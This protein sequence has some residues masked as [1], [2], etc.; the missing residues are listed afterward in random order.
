MPAPGGRRGVFLDRDGVLNQSLVRD[1]K[2]YAP[3]TLEEFVLLPGAAEAVCAL[4]ERGFVVVVVTNQPDIGNGLVDAAV[5]EAMHRRLRELTLVDDIRVCPHKQTDGCE[6][7]KPKPGMLLAAARDHGIDLG[8]SFMIGDRV[9]DLSAGKAAGCLTAF[10]DHG[11]GETKGRD[12][13]PDIWA[14]SLPDATLAI[15][16]WPNIATGRGGARD[17]RSG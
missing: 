13:S 10:V 14:K 17:E 6:C 12:L 5:V 9:S 8:N 7:R 15:M 2:P 11:Y 3:R 4:K 16:N 1:G